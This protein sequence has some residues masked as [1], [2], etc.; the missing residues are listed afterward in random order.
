MAKIWV[1]V[2]E[3]PDPGCRGKERR[4]KPGEGP[5]RYFTSTPEQVEDTADIA[6]LILTGD[7]IRTDGPEE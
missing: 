3:H 6:R 1:R 5:S 4:R 7:L 2:P